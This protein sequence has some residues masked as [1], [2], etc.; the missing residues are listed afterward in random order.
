MAMPLP[1]GTE[2]YWWVAFEAEA[3]PAWGGW[4]ETLIFQGVVLR[5]LTSS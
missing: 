4:Q 1:E 2:L 3:Q 5:T